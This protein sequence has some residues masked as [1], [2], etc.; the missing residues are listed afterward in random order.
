MKFSLRAKTIVLILAIA[1]MY[2]AV[3]I[4]VSGTF[5]RRLV[6]RTYNDQAR[7]VAATMAAVVDAE[8]AARLKS[9]MMEIYSTSSDRVTSDEWGS[10]AFEAYTARYA[11]LAD[12]EEY[13]ALLLQLRTIQDVNAVDCLYLAV[14]DQPTA[15]F[16]YL[17]GGA[18]EEPCPI[19]CI[20]PL[21]E[22][23]RDVLKHPERGFP[24]YIT[25]TQPYGALVT[26]GAPVYDADGGVV[27]Y[28]MADIS[29]A[30]LRE[31]QDRFTWVLGLLLA[32]LTVLTSLGAIALVNHTVIRPINM[33]S[34]AAAHYGAGRESSE[35]EHLSIRTQD[36]IESL[37]VSIKQMMR[38]IS[39]YIDNLMSTTQE[40]TRTRIKADRM[41][42]LANRDAL[43]GVGS[44]LAYDAMVSRLTD[45]IQQ[46]QAEFGIV[47]VDMNNLKTLNDTYGH[48][49]GNEAIKKTCA[50][51][52]EV[53]AH[54]PVYR[55][56]GDEFVVVVKGRDYQNI[57]ALLDRFTAAMAATEGEPWERLSA[58]TGFARYEG[59][60][61][62]EE[63]FRNADHI[64][65]ENKRAMRSGS[66]PS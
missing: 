45:E 14:V 37:Y 9:R 26:A 21:Y 57:D 18:H 54:S 16:L 49:R 11:P 46:G 42:E 19:G 10:P 23:N 30:N 1:A 4:V 36:E 44:K 29:M 5:T 6:D 63:V 28:A 27:C 34:S 17:V 12:T 56:G 32:G 40:L 61:T 60:N 35:I 24:P 31:Q 59:Q 7:N 13:A 50:I 58:A 51:L 8:R 55:V 43:T 65:Y 2:S 66:L 33:L 38:D 22:E 62:V 15:N 41:N 52:C 53:F 64:M 20:D 25:D 39:G 47:M 3:G 48:E